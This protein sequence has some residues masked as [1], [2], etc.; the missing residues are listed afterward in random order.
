MQPTLMTEW[1]SEERE[2]KL[3]VMW[4]A[5]PEL[6]E[7]ICKEY[8]NRI[9]RMLVVLAYICGFGLCPRSALSPVLV[10]T[11]DAT[12]NFLTCYFL[13]MRLTL[14]NHHPVVVSPWSFIL[15]MVPFPTL[16]PTLNQ[17]QLCIWVFL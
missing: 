3:I 5:Q 11:D 16:A 6:Y 9:K 10:A 1:L 14:I 7:V 2:V 17:I 15:E 8:S 13:N 12:H 4:Q